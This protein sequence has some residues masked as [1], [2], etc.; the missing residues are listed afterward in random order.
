MARTA[1]RA[2][3]LAVIVT[4]AALIA[5]LVAGLV[6]VVGQFS[7]AECIRPQTPGVVTGPPLQPTSLPAGDWAWIAVAVAFAGFLGGHLWGHRRAAYHWRRRAAEGN[8]PTDE[9][10]PNGVLQVLLFALFVAGALALGWETFAVAHVKADPTRWPITFFVRCAYD[11]A[12]V[13][14]LLAALVVST[15]VGHWLGYQANGTRIR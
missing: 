11:V 1:T 7:V 5:Y 13:P 10:R 4:C 3:L 12:T 15:M 6:G 2:G 14:T 9:T 8:D